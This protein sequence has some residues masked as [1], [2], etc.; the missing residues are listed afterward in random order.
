MDLRYIHCRSDEIQSDINTADYH[1]RFKYPLKNVKR[2]AISH[3]TMGNTVPV[4]HGERPQMEFLV[5]F[6]KTSTKWVLQSLKI[7]LDRGDY[8]T[9]SLAA[10]LTAKIDAKMTELG[11]LLPNTLG[12][13]IDTFTD[14][15]GETKLRINYTNN[16]AT[17]VVITP[18]G[19]F[20]S[21]FGLAN[22]Q[23]V[24]KGQ[25][26]TEIEKLK[27]NLPI[28]TSNIIDA[29]YSPFGTTI[30]P[31]TTTP[32]ET[33]EAKSILLEN[34]QGVLIS[35]DIANS[36]Y[37]TRGQQNWAE[38]TT[39]MELIHNTMPK[40]SFL[41]K[42]DGSLHWHKVEDESLSHFN[43]QVRTFDN[44]N[45]YKD[46]IRNFYIVFVFE[47]GEVM[48]AYHRDAYQRT[49]PMPIKNDDLS[50]TANVD[51]Y[52]RRAGRPQAS[53]PSAEVDP[54]MQRDLA[55]TNLLPSPARPRLPARTH[56]ERLQGSPTGP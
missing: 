46:D 37:D 24:A 38:R 31:G 41:H 49:H 18:V 47:I 16:A 9:S 27:A 19:N 55:T 23:Y 5:T 30:P 51:G 11:A 53:T 40:Y 33:V 28:G 2:C 21:I 26:D 25:V 39:T 32:P 36:S 22:T 13:T 50:A 8:N 43:F 29:N 35:S 14:G 48:T 34:V 52:R 3:F 12:I 4:I 56:Y 44:D 7:D 6:K 54:Q 1:V 15:H 45:H 17:P 42:S 20:W 10:E